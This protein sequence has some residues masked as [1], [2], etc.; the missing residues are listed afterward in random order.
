MATLSSLLRSLGYL[1]FIVC[2]NKV[3]PLALADSDRRSTGSS[4]E[5]RTRSSLDFAIS[6][7]GDRLE[8]LMI[9]SLG[10][11]AA[12]GSKTQTGRGEE[13]PEDDGEGHATGGSAGFVVVEAQSLEATGVVSGD[14][15]VKVNDIP[16]PSISLNEWI[17]QST[18][19]ILAT[20][21]PASDSST[22]RLAIFPLV[23]VSSDGSGTST[24][25]PLLHL[26]NSS[27]S[28]ENGFGN[29][30]CAAQPNDPTCIALASGEARPTA[31]AA[32][33][34]PSGTMENAQGFRLKGFLKVELVSLDGA[35]VTFR[36]GA[37]RMAELVKKRDEA[38]AAKKEENE[39]A[40][41]EAKA[42]LEAVRR[43]K[44]EE[45]RKLEAAAKAREAERAREQAEVE[46]MANDKRQEEARVR[47]EEAAAKLSAEK[48]KKDMV[49]LRKE[50]KEFTFTAEYKEVAPMGLTFDL[51]NPLAVVS[52]VTAGGLSDATGVKV[53]DHLVRVNERDTSEMKPTAALKVLQ[54]AVW[55]RVLTF[56]VP[57][58]LVVEGSDDPLL[59][60]LVVTEPEIVRGEYLMQAP[61]DWGGLRGAS[62][63]D[64]AQPSWSCE[65]RSM[66][67]SEPPPACQRNLRLLSGGVQVGDGGKPVIALV[68]RGVCTF[69]EKAKNV[70]VAVLNAAADTA[71]P[72][73]DTT[74]AAGKD[75]IT[76]TKA[77][78]SAAAASAATGSVSSRDSGSGAGGASGAAV[79]GGGMVLL[80][81]DDA[82]ADMPAG[83]LLTDDVNIPVAMI[84]RGNGS[85]V[86][87]LL[88]WGVE[89]R[90]AI[91]PY[92][93]CPL[94]P[95]TP[96]SDEQGAKA[97]K[98]DDDGGRLLVL[99][100]AQ[101]GREF[102][103]RLARYGPGVGDAEASPVAIA[104]ADP[105]DG[106]EDKAYKVRVSGMFA[107]VE[108]GGC[109]FS[110][111]TLAAQR[112]GALGVIIANTA[113]T[114]LRV[115]ADQGD[116][117]KALIPT[118]M[119]S[120]TA[121][122]FLSAAAAGSSRSPILGRFTRE[123]FEARRD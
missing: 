67:L 17:E 16:L 83:N 114:T 80:N 76:S 98:D 60:G 48:S 15:L 18:A 57:E 35:E 75:V 111:K 31:G 54:R 47:R 21:Q 65:P 117:E 53:G 99:S 22:A 26:S 42:L 7:A 88:S 72:P 63:E 110:M 116:G 81:G 74:A 123:A 23:D 73:Q 64:V 106:C 113:E 112:A 100:K 93:A 55:P 49:R 9:T 62:E 61:K 105:F 50:G 34:S 84:S 120:A 119:V 33:A 52:E 70:Q 2:T 6:G 101:G 97:R 37:A 5:A 43:E 115:M 69:V 104:V 19:T 68:K 27:A 12:T 14:R 103:Y 59:L 25:Q 1:P 89:V 8:G 108:R 92:G 10:D 96:S 44:E 46:R 41:A 86:E 36:P 94:P 121:G 87:A 3:I 4:V 78:D 66:A 58:S 40:L 91:S 11:L 13:R 118:V 51:A 79:V 77:A 102:N 82:L 107:V 85:S 29:Q 39:R 71:A 109:S 38:A 20:H 95:P 32:A 24:K 90:A 122:G 30:R 45:D 28:S 56:S